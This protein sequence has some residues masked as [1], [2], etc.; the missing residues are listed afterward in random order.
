[1]LVCKYNYGFVNEKNSA[2]E[3]SG[4]FE[5]VSATSIKWLR[6]EAAVYMKL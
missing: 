5:N 4:L 3:K 2:L 1:M 6:T